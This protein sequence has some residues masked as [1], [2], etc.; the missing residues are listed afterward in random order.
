MEFNFNELKIQ[1]IR[2]GYNQR[3]FAEKLGISASNY[4]QKELGKV[5]TTINEFTRMLTILK[6]NDPTI[7]FIQ[8]KTI[9]Q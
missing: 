5:S 4:S 7:F 3:Q 6:I 2:A 1:R 8:N 9:Y